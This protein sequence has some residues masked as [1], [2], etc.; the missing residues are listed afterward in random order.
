MRKDTQ[1]ELKNAFSL[2][3]VIIVYHS[4]YPA[5]NVQDR[6]TECDIVACE[7]ADVVSSATICY[8]TRS[9]HRPLW[10]AALAAIIMLEEWLCVNA[11]I[12]FKSACNA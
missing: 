10:G 8:T 12:S 7:G 2:G 3:K 6:I 1:A 9:I 5:Q 11:E 4:S